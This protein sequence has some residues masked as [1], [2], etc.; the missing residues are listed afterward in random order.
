[1]S[2]L[3]HVVKILGMAGSNHNNYYNGKY[4]IAISMHVHVHCMRHM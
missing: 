4:Y 2:W 1:M 3:K